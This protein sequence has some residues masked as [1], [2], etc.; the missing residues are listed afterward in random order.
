NYFW[1][2][3]LHQYEGKKTRLQLLWVSIIFNC[4]FLLYFKYSNFFILNLNTASGS[5]FALIE[6]LIL[7]VGISFYTFQT[8]SY[9]VDVYR[10]SIK[11]C[12][13]LLD[14]AFYLSFF[15]QLVA[16]PIV[17]AKD[18]L[19]QIHQKISFKKEDMGQ[20]LY[21]ILKGLV[22]KAII[23]DYVA[24]YV[25][26]V[27]ANPAGYSGFEHLMAMYAYTLQIYCDFSGYSDMAI[28]L[29]LLMGFRLPDNFKS[30]Y[31]AADITEF[32]RRWHI[33]LSTWL[34]DYIYIPLGGNRKGEERQFAN[35]MITMLVGGFWH[36]ASWKFVFWGG[37]HGLGL[38]VHKI[39]N[40]TARS[41]E[42]SPELLRPIG[43]LIN[44]H[45]V[46]LLWIFFRA[47][48]FGDAAW[49]IHQ[50]I[51]NLDWAYFIPFLQTRGLVFL[52][53][54]VGFALHF[55]RDMDKLKLAE[56]YSSLPVLAKAGILLLIVQIILQVQNENV[57]PFIYFQF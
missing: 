42:W 11:P 53:I 37:M 10:R 18:F 24:Q 1:A 7:P 13:N 16:G 4:S 51:F 31:N 28:G 22:K 3:F 25:N 32:W 2:H 35:L 46:A 33:T 17:R 8:I 41:M 36:G 55:V 49:S 20:G 52:F 19:P 50:M 43:W 44:F 39:F 38:I 34:R 5:S 27:Y 47:A 21:M 12:D 29:A 14:F 54:V 57:Q 15:P 23:A 40:Q 45:F 48:N 26:L 30:P 6:D 9:I 56:Y